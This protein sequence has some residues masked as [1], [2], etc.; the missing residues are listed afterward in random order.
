[1]EIKGGRNLDRNKG[2]L[3]AGI[4]FLTPI[5]MLVFSTMLYYSGFSPDGTTNNG[6]LIDPPLETSKINLKAKH[7]PLKNEF[8]GKWTIVYFLDKECSEACWESLYKSRQVNVRL[9]RDS[10]R[11]NRYLVLAEG[12]QLNKSQEEK[13]LKEYP[14]LMRGSIEPEGNIG[15]FRDGYYLFDPLGNGIIFY[16]SELPGG[17]LLEDLKK[18]FKNSKI[19]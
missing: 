18:L 16:P 6:E 14:S 17:E 8:P 7:G 3:I 13:I 4:I 9:G 19:G 10:T 12:F 5:V 15:L 11:L 2:R 1:M